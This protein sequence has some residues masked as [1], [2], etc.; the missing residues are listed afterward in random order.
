MKRARS[1][2]ATA[3]TQT[4]PVREFAV[5]SGVT[6]KAL[7]HYERLGLMT[8][9]RTATGH[10]R[11]AAR[12]R[13]RLRSIVALKGLGVPLTRMRDLLDATPA[14][15]PGLLAGRRA[16]ITHERQRL[17]RAE[18]AVSLVEERLRHSAGDG[19]G[20]ACLA[21]VLEMPRDIDALKRY[22]SDGA[23]EH[24]KRFYQDWP[25]ES[26]VALYRDIHAALPDGP[27][28]TRGEE[29]L[30]RWNTLAASVW[31]EFAPDPR[32]NREL[33]DGFARAWR[34]RA[35]WPETIRRRFADYH[36]D[37][38]AAFLGQLSIAVFKR[39]GPLWFAA[40]RERSGHVA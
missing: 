40:Q 1:D 17:D 23:W 19:R 31:R 24:A 4:Y 36:L 9:A 12:D 33:H 14:T 3:A 20:L 27:E 11:Y 2:T 35:E 5:R 6:V 28:T 32:L 7:L 10:R 21:D 15:L 8:P 39:R 37:E 30:D 13:E 26:W 25:R 29:L 16:A 38:I 22:F 34:A 18:R